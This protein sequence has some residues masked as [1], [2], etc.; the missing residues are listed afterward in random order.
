[1]MMGEI[2]LSREFEA[3]IQR[4][5]DSGQYENEADVV[6]AA[7]ALLDAMDYSSDPA[8]EINDAFDD[9]S[10]DISLDAAFQHINE[11]YLRDVKGRT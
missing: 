2:K 4:H 6:S 3:I 10:E 1:M 8:K 7:L 11:I 5:I 9:G